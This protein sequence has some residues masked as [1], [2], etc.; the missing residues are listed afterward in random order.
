MLQIL[1]LD[2]YSPDIL[3]I[4]A[5]GVAIAGLGIGLVT[6]SVMSDRGFGPYGNGFLAILG[7][8][9]GIYTRHAFFGWLRGQEVLIIGSFAIATA[10][11]M[12]LLLGVAKH[13]VQD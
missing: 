8:V 5:L 3:A 11:L 4:T 1:G 6:D 9:T 12:L 13:W 2:Q 10:T 7:G